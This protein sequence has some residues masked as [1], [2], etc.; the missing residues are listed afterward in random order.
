ML[1]H[2]HDRGVHRH[3]PVQLTGRV[4]P[5]LK[6]S[7]QFVPG[8]ISG[9]PMMPLPHRLPRP[10]PLGQV[11]PRDPSPQPID[12]PF[13][14]LTVIAKRPATLTVRGRQQPFDPGPRSIIQYR[15][16]RHERIIRPEHAHIRETRP[17]SQM[18]C[19]QANPNLHVRRRMFRYEGSPTDLTVALRP[20]R[21]GRDRHRHGADDQGYSWNSCW[22]VPPRRLISEVWSP[23]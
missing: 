4:R 3:R 1:V 8:A 22:F 10:E 20:F 11:T 7:E 6:V 19:L 21:T 17:R 12:D 9:E 18:C 13:D 23:K 16:S 14:H 5:H 2:P 15:R